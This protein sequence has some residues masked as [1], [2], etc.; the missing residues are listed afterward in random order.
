MSAES[1]LFV[2]PVLAGVVGFCFLEVQ[3]EHSL[4]GRSLWLTLAGLLVG[5]GLPLAYQAALGGPVVQPAGFGAGVGGLTGLILA[6]FLHL[7]DRRPAEGEN[8]AWITWTFDADG[9][10]EL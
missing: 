9:E 2:L 6:L 3:Q 10:E 5:G 7:T 1:A 4:F 8:R